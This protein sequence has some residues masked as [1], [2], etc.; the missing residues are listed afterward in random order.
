MRGYLVGTMII[1]VQKLIT[2]QTCGGKIYTIETPIRT[3]I[4]FL[5]MFLKLIP[6]SNCGHDR[7]DNPGHMG[8]DHRGGECAQGIWV[9][10]NT[11]QELDARGDQWGHMADHQTRAGPAAAEMDKIL[12]KPD[13]AWRALQT[14][15]TRTAPRVLYKEC[16]KNQALDSVNHTIDGCGEFLP[17][18]VIVSQTSFVS[19]IF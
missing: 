8:E 16:L 1:Y 5:N 19:F 7:W 14:V 4:I 18:G 3:S 2:G 10:N 12:S 6:T 9:S 11:H 17:E 15:P 13:R